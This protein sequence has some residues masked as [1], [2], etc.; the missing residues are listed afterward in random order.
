MYLQF[1]LKSYES[2]NQSTAE[3]IFEFLKLFCFPPLFI[4]WQ[5]IS[6]LKYP[7]GLVSFSSM[8]FRLAAVLALL[9]SSNVLS[10]NEQD[11]DEIPVSTDD[12]EQQVIKIGTYQ[13]KYDKVDVSYL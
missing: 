9:C 1:K 4:F 5:N 10:S 2:Q 6:F 7:F 12:L 3:S 11:P 8:D 13:E